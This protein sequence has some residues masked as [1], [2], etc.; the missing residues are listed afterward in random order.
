MVEK[1]LAEEVILA[2]VALELSLK[3]NEVAIRLAQEIESELRDLQMERTL[4]KVQISRVEDQ[5][6]EG[7][8]C[9]GIHHKFSRDGVA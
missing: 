2:H 7:I 5:N 3:R 6:N 8:N 9:E 4:F 1:K